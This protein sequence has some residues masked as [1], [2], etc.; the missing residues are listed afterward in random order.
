MKM[1]GR[2]ILLLSMIMAFLTAC[3]TPTVSSDDSDENS[4]KVEQEDRSSSSGMSNSKEA[5]RSSS[6]EKKTESSSSEN[7][8]ESSDVSADKVES[9]S[10]GVK[11]TSWSYLNPD[12]VYSEIID[13]R[14][15]QAYKIVKIGDQWW[16]AENLNFDPGQG[17]S[18]DAKYDW[19]WCYKDNA[20]NCVKSSRK[21]V[22]LALAITCNCIS[23]TIAFSIR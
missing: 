20:D 4:E 16:M 5:D 1:I 21:S 2:T 23:L 7:L 8:L 14:D 11:K 6:S 17:G 10:S 15:G 19:S 22:S 13:E 9:S 12:I 3:S 18:D